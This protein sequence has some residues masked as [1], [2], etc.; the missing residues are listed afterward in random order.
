MYDCD[1]RLKKVLIKSATTSPTRHN[2][3]VSYDSFIFVD[4]LTNNR[5]IM[6]DARSQYELKLKKSM[7]DSVSEKD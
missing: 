5:I 6:K 4:G 2:S 7:Q 3:N 1:K